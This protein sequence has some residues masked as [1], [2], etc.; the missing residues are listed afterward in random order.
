MKGAEHT[1][2]ALSP[3]A[4]DEAF[5][6]R[7]LA[8]VELYRSLGWFVVPV[9]PGKKKPR[10]RWKAR[11]NK[12]LSD[13][14]ISEWFG[15]G[16][17]DP[18]VILGRSSNALVARDFDTEDAY[19]TWTAQHIDLATTLPTV[20]TGRA[21]HVY[22]RSDYQTFH[23]LDETGEFRTDGHLCVLPPGEHRSGRRYEWIVEPSPESLRWIPA[24][25]VR[26]LGFLDSSAG[27]QGDLG[28]ATDPRLHKRT[29][30][31]EKKPP[32]PSYVNWRDLCE[33][34]ASAVSTA[35]EQTAAVVVGERHYQVFQFAR[36]LR[37]IGAL[38]GRNPRELELFVRAW[39]ERSLPHIG[40]TDWETTWVDFL[41][42]WP[43][44]KRPG[45]ED[46]MDDIMRRAK[47]R[48]FEGYEDE[49]TNM[50]AGVC[51]ELQ[52][53]AGDEPFYLALRTAG[54]LLGQS[55]QWVSG[56][57]WLFRDDGLLERVQTGTARGRRA[58]R[59]RWLGPQGRGAAR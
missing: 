43:R 8:A 12:H 39:F 13:E 44:V 5:V 42:A 27:G 19:D 41:Q 53:V 23:R 7:L 26:R 54:R 59:Y 55:H 28:G 37:G 51:R 35:I 50:L 22:F 34:D 49:A 1:M 16:E 17:N 4:R 3:P 32:A 31:E 29:D 45:N 6:A 9:E 48:P 30:Q 18:G 11:H 38:A 24:R 21:F 20:R 47:A 33:A 52:E 40:T 57:L 2:V 10:I 25:D 14:E 56:R 36:K 46:F 58:S 15:N